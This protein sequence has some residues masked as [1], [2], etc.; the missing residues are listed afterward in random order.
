MVHL[1][2]DRRVDKE[3]REEE[4][5]GERRGEEKRRYLKKLA[6]LRLHGLI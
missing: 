2:S 3:E 1:R 6:V 5:R 4:R